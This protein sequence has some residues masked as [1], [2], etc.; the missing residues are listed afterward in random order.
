MLF[1]PGILFFLSYTYCGF[2][3]QAVSKLKA[4]IKNGKNTIKI[5]QK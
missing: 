4:K 2:D 3:E 1:Y 5:R